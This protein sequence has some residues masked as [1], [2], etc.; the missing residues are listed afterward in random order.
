MVIYSDHAILVVDKPAGLL[1]LPDGFDPALPYLTQR[2]EPEYGK[3]WI[4][5]RLDRETSGVMVLARSA[6]AHRDLNTQ[7]EQ[8]EVKKIYHAL[9]NGEPGWE[10]TVCDLPLRAGAG[11]RKRTVAG[12]GG[13]PALTR[14]QVLE[15]FGNAA[16]VE[17]RPETGR[18][19]QVRAHL[20]ALGYPILGDALYTLPDQVGSRI[21][22]LMLHAFSLA[23]RHPSTGESISFEAP[24]PADFTK[25][26]E[27]L[28]K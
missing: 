21:N 1:A 28:R 13:K 3:L 7:F 2:L 25:A 24:Y 14:F 19:H 4:V 5:H 17:A 8:R 12:P 18:T 26:I 9:V 6:Q 15:R 11:R 16:L 22:R 20:Y 27:H 10:E 23:F